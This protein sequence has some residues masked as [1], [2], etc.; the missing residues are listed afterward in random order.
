[1]GQSANGAGRDWLK[2][3]A[4]AEYGFRFARNRKEKLSLWAYSVKL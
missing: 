3:P 2:K 1:M 4:I